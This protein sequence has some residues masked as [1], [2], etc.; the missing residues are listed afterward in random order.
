LLPLPI[1]RERCL[2]LYF[3]KSWE[4]GNRSRKKGQEKRENKYMVIKKQQKQKRKERGK[5]RV[6][7]SST[8]SRFEGDIYYERQ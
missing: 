4:K 6:L 5:E 2:G 1:E 7:F 8:S 3:T